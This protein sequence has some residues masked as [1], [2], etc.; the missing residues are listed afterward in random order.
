V[1]AVHDH[2]VEIRS[3][4]FDTVDKAK[5]SEQFDTVDKAKRSEQFDTVD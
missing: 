2:S 3:E 4:Q 5:R 1:E